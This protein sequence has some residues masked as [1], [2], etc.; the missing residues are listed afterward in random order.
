MT[1]NKLS[2]EDMKRVEQFLNT[3]V[4]QVERQPFKPMKLLFIIT[5]VVIGFGVL[6]RVVGWF[7]LNSIV[8]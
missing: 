2:K 8:S 6:S 5:L 4:N 3:P 7:Y 1:N